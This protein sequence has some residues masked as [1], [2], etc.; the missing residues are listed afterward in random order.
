MEESVLNDHKEI[1]YNTH[2][3]VLLRKYCVNVFQSNDGHILRSVNAE[4]KMQLFY[5][6]QLDS[7]S[8]YTLRIT[9]EKKKNNGVDSNFTSDANPFKNM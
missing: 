3:K 8:K 9:K 7:N 1:H 2:C 4:Y 6:F 5:A